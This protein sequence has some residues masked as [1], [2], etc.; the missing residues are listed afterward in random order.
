MEQ[1]LAERATRA[2]PP[3]LAVL[4]V[5][6]RPLARAP[7]PPAAPAARPADAPPLAAA[8]TPAARTLVDELQISQPAWDM[9]LELNRHWREVVAGAQRGE[10]AAD[11]VEQTHQAREH[12][13]RRI[14]GE[15]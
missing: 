4:P 9:M 1:Q 11:T 6:E 7:E 8:R 12:K 2:A 13:L 14:L 3:Q 10:Q 5:V 15:D